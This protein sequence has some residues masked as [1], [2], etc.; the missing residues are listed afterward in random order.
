M[1]GTDLVLR[2]SLPF[3]SCTKRLV[4]YQPFDPIQ[5]AID[6]RRRDIAPDTARSEDPDIADEAATDPRADLFIV[7]VAFAWRTS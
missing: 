7:A 4:E 1:S 2:R 3:R 5:T 6:T